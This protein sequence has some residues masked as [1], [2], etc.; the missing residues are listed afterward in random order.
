MEL[1][2]FIKI[3]LLFTIFVTSF[4]I[5]V[6]II[7]AFILY[8]YIYMYQNWLKKNED[9]DIQPTKIKNTFLNNGYQTI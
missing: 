5:S 6:V 3:P 9:C 7:I 8:I 2:Y 1:P 4:M